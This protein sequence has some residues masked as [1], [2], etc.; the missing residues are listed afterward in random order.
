MK[1]VVERPVPTFWGVCHMNLRCFCFENLTVLSTAQARGWPASH[2]TGACSQPSDPA[3]GLPG[4]TQR[5]FLSQGG[6]VTPAACHII[7]APGVQLVSWLPRPGYLGN[8]YNVPE[9]G[10]LGQWWGKIPV[11]TIMA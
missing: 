10:S 8:V 9:A 7:C 6:E 4:A 1:H 3:V 2:W 5:K 11:G